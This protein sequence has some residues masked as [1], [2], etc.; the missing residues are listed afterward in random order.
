MMMLNRTYRNATPRVYS[1]DD[2]R[3]FAPSVFQDHA[4]ERTSAKY[5]HYN[6]ARVLETLIANDWQIIGAS[7]ARTRLEDKQGFQKHMIR[8]QHPQLSGDR[9]LLAKVGDTTFGN[10]VITNSSYGDAAYNLMLGLLRLAC[11]NGL[12]V[13]EP[14][15]EQ[16]FRHTSVTE[17]QIIEA[18]FR[19]IEEFPMVAGKVE[20]F[21]AITMT[22][23]EQEVFAE[24]ARELRWDSEAGEVAPIEPKQ[25]LRAQRQEDRNNDL[26]TTMN[27]VQEH[28]ITG[29]VHGRNRNGGRTTT[30]AV[31]GVDANVKLNKAL[32]KLTTEM[33][34]LKGENV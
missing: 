7:E 23:R 34:K 10:I 24:A 1:L 8:L 5:N 4:H 22:P 17:E 15:F 32:W 19:V 3:R 28:L 13:D 21:R 20:T 6:T 26:Y 11:T 14:A 29:G 18:Q 27:V 30:R 33:A 9:S 12:I 2:V 25:L 31:S 16:R